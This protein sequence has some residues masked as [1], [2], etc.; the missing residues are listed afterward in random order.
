MSG[1]FRSLGRGERGVDLKTALRVRRARRR[2][3]CG[4]LDNSNLKEAGI[5]LVSFI[6]LQCVRS[7]GEFECETT[8]LRFEKL[9]ALWFEKLV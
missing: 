1:Q 8:A 7:F 4:W 6:R 9:V 5:A 2:L 3:G